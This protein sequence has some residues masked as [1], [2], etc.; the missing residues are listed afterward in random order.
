MDRV[1]LLQKAAIDLVVQNISVYAFVYIC[2]C[3]I[4]KCL[5]CSEVLIYKVIL[6]SWQWQITAIPLYPCSTESV[7]VVH[8]SVKQTLLWVHDCTSWLT[9]TDW[10][11][12]PPHTKIHALFCFRILSFTQKTCK[13]TPLLA[14]VSHIIHSALNPFLLG[15]MRSWIRRKH[16]FRRTHAKSWIHFY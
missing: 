16:T 14:E 6:C 2:I 8:G 13:N 4:F 9:M 15:V 1:H 3:W 12:L 5:L 7:V 11:P 10:P